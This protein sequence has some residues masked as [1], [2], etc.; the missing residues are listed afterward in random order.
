MGVGPFH[1]SSSCFEKKKVSESSFEKMYPAVFDPKPKIKKL[2]NP[3]PNNYIIREE[4]T[5]LL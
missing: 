2:P 1:V 4:E 5:V 3:D